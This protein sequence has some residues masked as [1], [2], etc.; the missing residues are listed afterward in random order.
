MVEELNTQ[1]HQPGLNQPLT[2]FQVHTLLT[3]HHQA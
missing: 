2:M 3:L 1:F